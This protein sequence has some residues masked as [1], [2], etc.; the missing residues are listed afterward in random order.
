MGYPNSSGADNAFKGS[1]EGI[2][3]YDSALTPSQIKARFEASRA[4]L[5]H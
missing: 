1:I 3:V 4:R 5:S 2:A